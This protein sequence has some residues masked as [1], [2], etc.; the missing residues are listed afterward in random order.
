[1]DKSI[2][3]IPKYISRP[4]KNRNTYCFKS[5]KAALT[6]LVTKPAVSRLS[7]QV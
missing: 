6:M 5:Q 1:M 4:L 2:Q 3:A 7:L